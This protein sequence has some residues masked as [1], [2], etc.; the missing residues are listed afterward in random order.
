MQ[1]TLTLEIAGLPLINETVD[2]GTLSPES[3]H[4]FA[5]IA[6]GDLLVFF[7]VLMVGFAYL[8]KRGDIDWVRVVPGLQPGDRP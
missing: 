8:W 1:K 3:A 7:A 5:W 6:F 2:K 4:Q